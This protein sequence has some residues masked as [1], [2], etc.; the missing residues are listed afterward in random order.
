MKKRIPEWLT[1]GVA[2]VYYWIMALYKLTVAPIWQ[3]EAMEYYCSIPVKGAIRGVTEYATMYE[4]MAYIQQQPPLYNWLMCIWL[5]IYDSEW[6][7]RFSSVIFGFIAVIGLYLVLKRLCD[8]F[9][10][11]LAV[12]VFSSIHYFQYYTKEASEYVLLIAMLIWTV[13]VYIRILEGATCKNVIIFSAMCVI[14]M[15]THYSAA[16]VIVPMALQ[17]LYFCWKEGAKKEFGAFLAADAI[18]AITTGIPLILLY[19]LPQSTNSNSSLRTDKEIAFTNG[20][21]ILDFFDSIRANLSWCLLDYDR[22]GE[23]FTWGVWIVMAVWLCISCIC[24]I[25]TKRRTIRYFLGGNALIYLI[26]YGL[27]KCNLYA[28]GDFHNRYNLFLLPIWF[29]AIVL[30]LHESIQLLKQTSNPV[31]KKTVKYAEILV[32]A[33]AVLFTAYGMKRLRD[34]WDKSDMRTVEATWYEEG[35]KET[36]TFVSYHLRYAFVYYLTH[37]DRYTENDWKDIYTS[38]NLDTLKFSREEWIEYLQKVVYPNGLPERLYVISGYKDQ[39]V[40]ALEDIGYEVSPIVDTTAKLYL[41]TA[42]ENEE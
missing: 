6:W 25:R 42:P 14:D 1:A 38:Q 23:R 12:F 36:E 8:R 24:F 30:V 2:F 13:Y 39:M 22:D 31:I 26:Y 35:G 9:T 3:D 18:A 16:F 41:L 4:R 34:H 33:G 15:Y 27:T 17:L 7:Y 10:A 37:D 19:V 32:I 11:T 28:Y 29:I 5:E 20:N 21:V 40:W